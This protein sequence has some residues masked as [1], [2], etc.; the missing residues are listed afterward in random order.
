M[1]VCFLYIYKEKVFNFIMDNLR[2]NVKKY[3]SVDWLSPKDKMDILKCIIELSIKLEIDPLH[4]DVYGDLYLIHALS[5]S[6]NHCISKKI[7]KYGI[8]HEIF[9]Q[10]LLQS[11]ADALNYIKTIKAR[12]YYNLCCSFACKKNNNVFTNLSI[13]LGATLCSYCFNIKHDTIR[14]I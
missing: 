3:M 14:I 11:D 8:G 10:H 7:C 9:N 13:D 5:L 2:K 4:G 1:F 6:D 12:T